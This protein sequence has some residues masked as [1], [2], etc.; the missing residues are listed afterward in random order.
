MK[1]RTSFHPTTGSAV[2][3][4]AT[5]VIGIFIVAMLA[6]MVIPLG[7]IVLWTHIK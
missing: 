4:V 2:S 5:F 7:L 3:K 1:G 6:L